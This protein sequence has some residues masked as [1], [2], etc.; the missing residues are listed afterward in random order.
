MGG[1]LGVDYDGS[2]TTFSSSMNYTISEY[3]ADVVYTTKDICAQE[4][5]PMLST[6]QNADRPTSS[7]VLGRGVAI[8]ETRITSECQGPAHRPTPPRRPPILP[9]HSPISPSTPPAPG[10]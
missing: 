4:Q 8:W 10:S 3:A 5:V 6:H 2:K 9:G 1:G 7:S